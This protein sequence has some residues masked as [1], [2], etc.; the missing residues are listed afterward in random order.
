[1]LGTDYLLGMRLPL[2][3]NDTFANNL[4]LIYE[5][6]CDTLL[7]SLRPLIKMTKGYV[8][9]GDGSV[10]Q[11]DMFDQGRVRRYFETF[12]ASLSGW[13]VA[14]PSIS[15]TDDLHRLYCQ[16]SCEVG[17]FYLYG[18]FGIQFHALPYY[19]VDK[20]V[21]EV[22]KELVQLSESEKNI[23]QS[24]SQQG[25]TAIRSELNKLGYDTL[26][27]QELFT[28][29]IDN[30]A[31][32]SELEKKASSIENQYP[33]Y[34]R[35]QEQKSKLFEELNALIVEVYQIASVKIDYNKLMQGE[36]GVVSYFDIEV[37]KN[38][39][40]N[41]RDAFINTQRVDLDLG[42]QV[43]QKLEDVIATLKRAIP[44]D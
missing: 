19:K 18:Y 29:L 2:K 26:E 23:D 16:V 34:H 39:K 24:I 4:N 44:P 32:V 1:M 9:L 28:K 36:E 42:K 33:Q 22:Q 40:T 37:I 35:I 17:K 10:T 14:P 30:P 20:R 5:Q 12:L 21:I 43:S 11:V 38:R 25:D 15:T 7:S 8:M 13:S 3:S 27:F 6:I 41:E 31:L